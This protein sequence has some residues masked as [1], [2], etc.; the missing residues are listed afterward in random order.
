MFLD[1]GNKTML[2]LASFLELYERKILFIL[3]YVVVITVV[4]SL[5][6]N[7]TN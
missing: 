2:V 7:E 6:D 5:Q 3:K 1:Q 4:I